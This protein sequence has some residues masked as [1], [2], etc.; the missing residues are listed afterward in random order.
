M[1]QKFKKE[2]IFGDFEHFR[3]NINTSL[4]DAEMIFFE[5]FFLQKV[6]LIYD[7]NIVQKKVGVTWGTFLPLFGAF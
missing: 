1:P 7:Y 3:S 5:N 4:P 6:T 2:L